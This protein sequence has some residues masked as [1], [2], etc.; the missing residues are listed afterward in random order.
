MAMSIIEESA[1]ESASEYSSETED[2]QVEF[3]A[4]SCGLMSHP[5]IKLILR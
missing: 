2:F 1:S 4:T 5:A 3:E